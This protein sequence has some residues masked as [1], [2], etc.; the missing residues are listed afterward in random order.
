M[1]IRHPNNPIISPSDIKIEND[2]L[3]VLGVFNPGATIHGD[4]SVLLLRVALKCKA[5]KGW[6]KI[7]I[8]DKSNNYKFRILRWK[9]RK[10]LRIKKSDPRFI[11]INDEK[12]LTSLSV[13]YLA[14]SNDGSNFVISESPV[15]SPSNEYEIYG[16][17]DPRITKLDENYF[18]TYTAVSENSYCSSL[19]STTDF[20]N[21]KRLGIIFPPENKDVALFPKKI[22]NKFYCLH[23][24]TISFIGKPAIWISESDDLIKWGNHQLLL[25]PLE[26]KWEKI[27]I[28]CGPEPLLTESG[29]LV[30]Y[31]S[32]GENEIYYL[33]AV[34]L[35][36]NNP[37]RVLART[38]KPLLTPKHWYEK[39][40][41]VPNVVFSNG[42]VRKNDKVLIYYGSADTYVSLVEIEISDLLSHLI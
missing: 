24:P 30:L 32:C 21:F 7:L 18:I 8:C 14:E 20:K 33:S 37:S 15:F 5:E 41:V 36:V 29:W 17:E 10:S 6:I 16:V 27:K 35:D 26:N 19:A 38:K 23:R 28:G 11:I 25:T 1:I 9:K 42:W 4:T 22:N 40:G 34:L 13:F 12:F 39:D 31:H 3:Q 2:E